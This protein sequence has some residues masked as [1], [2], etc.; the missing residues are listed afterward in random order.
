MRLENIEEDAIGSFSR[1]RS[2]GHQYLK[3]FENCR[4]QDEKVISVSFVNKVV[5]R[6]D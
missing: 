5:W 3:E 2:Q 1:K 6:C 4:R